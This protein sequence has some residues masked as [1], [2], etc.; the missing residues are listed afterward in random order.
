MADANGAAKWPAVRLGEVLQQIDRTETVDATALYKLLGVRLDGGG[1]FHRETKLGSQISAQTLSRVKEGDFIY[2]RLFAWRGAF[3]V[4]PESL[5]DHFVSSEFP[6]FAPVPEC[7]DVHYLK[8]WFRLKSTLDMVEENCSGS[9]PLT[10]NRFKEQYFFALEIPLPALEEQRRIVARIEALAAKINHAQ[11][12]REQSIEAMRNLARSLVVADGQLTAIR[13]LV[14]L[15]PHDVKV[16]PT[17]T[18]HFAG[19]YSFGE[20]VFRGQQKSGADFAYKQLTRLRTGNFVFPK[21]MAWEGAFG[22]VPDDCDGLVVSPEFP[23]FEVDE[24]KIL[25]EV[26][27]V[28]FKTPSVWPQ[29]S[30]IST[31]TNVRRRRLNP[32]V[33]LNY[34][35]PVPSREI[36]VKLRAVQKHASMIR[37]MQ[38]QTAGEMDALLPAGLDKAFKG[39]L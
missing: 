1:A 35:M 8:Y 29:V 25:P 6:L 4:I 39:E 10:R 24:D 32:Q 18:Y 9:T 20:G 30:S 27:D 38:N 23:V 12:I 33:F 17:E 16:N 7:V 2:S 34:K 3:D 11:V 14:R 26:L 15:R 5:N 19:V 13:D 31:G 36:Q 22:I 21:L 37:Q 28:Y